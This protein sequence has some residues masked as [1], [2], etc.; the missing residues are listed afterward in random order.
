MLVNAI[1]YRDYPVV[2]AVILFGVMFAIT[3]LIVDLCYALVD[4]E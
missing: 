2:Q 4:Q 1:A 3:N